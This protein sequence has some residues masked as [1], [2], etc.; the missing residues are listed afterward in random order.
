MAGLLMLYFVKTQKTYPGFKKLVIA[1]LISGCGYILLS[2]RHFI[3]PFFSIVLANLSII[4]CW[5]IIKDGLSDFFGTRL[6]KF[7]EYLLFIIIGIIFAYFSL[8]QPNLAA[9]SIVKILYLLYL[10][11]GCAVLT[12]KESKSLFGSPLLMIPSLFSGLGAMLIA[13]TGVF[14]LGLQAEDY[15]KVGTIN[16]IVTIIIFTLNLSIY[17]GLIS[18]NSHRL[19]TDLQSSLNEIKT[20]KDLLPICSHCKKIRD[21][22]GYWNEIDAYIVEHTEA[23]FSHSI[24]KECADKYY[25]DMNLY[26]EDE[27]QG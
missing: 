14:Y 18:L 7:R 27:V 1:I 2:L 20:L 23:E 24:C 12:Y 8:I 3:P 15:M 4:V 21:D 6:N 19:S 9:R 10:V 25:P 11:I 13:L 17:F 5:L 16:S 22:K 26:D